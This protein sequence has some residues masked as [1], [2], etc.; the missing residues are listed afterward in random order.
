MVF[1]ELSKCR[2]SRGQWKK[3][4]EAKEIQYQEVLE[5]KTALQKDTQ[6]L[7]HQLLRQGSRINQVLEEWQNSDE[8]WR[9]M[10]KHV[11][12]DN[13]R[14]SIQNR[15]EQMYIEHITAQVKKIVHES[16][17]MLEK[18]QA[19]IKE[20]YPQGNLGQH[21]QDFLEEARG[22]YEQITSFYE[23]NSDALNF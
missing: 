16:R 15:G 5:K 6:V 23:A 13:T 21:L 1:E 12:D 14:L 7:K 10:Y 2:K 20:Y 3:K 8:N 9:R 18:M 22:Q 19:L 17:R 11:S 4:A